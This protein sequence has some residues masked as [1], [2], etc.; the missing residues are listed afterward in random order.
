VGKHE[1]KNHSEDQGLDRRMGLKETLR[2]VVGGVWSGFTRLRIG[3]D[4]KLL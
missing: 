1:G 4:G 2:T 3:I